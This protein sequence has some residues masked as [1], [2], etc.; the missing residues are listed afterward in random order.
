MG[1]LK[2]TTASHNGAFFDA[3]QAPLAK[4]QSSTIPVSGPCAFFSF[5]TGFPT[6]F[7]PLSEKISRYLRWFLCIF[8]FLTL[9]TVF[10]ATLGHR[11]GSGA[12]TLLRLYAIGT[13]FLSFLGFCVF[14][15]FLH[16]TRTLTQIRPT[17]GQIRWLLV[18]LLNNF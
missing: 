6:P 12:A 3:R 1:C 14:L 11:H 17:L 4:A 13:R 15:L 5:F 10:Q 9:F 8:A 18:V 7:A 16:F 2:C